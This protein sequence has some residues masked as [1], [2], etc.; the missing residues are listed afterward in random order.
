MKKLSLAAMV[1]V[2]LLPW[3]AS[4]QSMAL[5]QD[6]YVTPGNATNY[7]TS[8][9]IN[10]GGPP[11]SQ[12]LIQFDLSSLPPGTTSSQV[13]KA[14]LV[15][16]VNNILTNGTMNVN[17]ADGPWTENGV[18]G[19]N[20]PAVGNAV[21]TGISVTVVH[22]YYVID[23]TQAVKDWIGGAHSNN[24]FII[25]QSTPGGLAMVLDSKETTL[26]SHPATLTVVLSGLAGATGSRG[27]AGATGATGATGAGATGATGAAGN[28]GLTGATGAVGAT[29]VGTT[30]AIGA[31]GA[32]GAQ[33]NSVT[34]AQ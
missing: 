18:N 6:T 23:A 1:A 5:V 28:T 21:A 26:T 3:A 33:G 24:G 22:S 8:I 7:G 16:F 12:G 29:G 13:A 10:V 19:L 17:E 27:P 20:Q 9:S 32:A 4:A 11:A 14:T 30:G 2:I 15:L 31:T 34:G 25:T